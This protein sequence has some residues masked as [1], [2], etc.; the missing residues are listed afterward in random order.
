MAVDDEGVIDLALS[1]ET[2]IVL[3][4]SDHLAWNSF[5]DD[6]LLDDQTH[7]ELLA[8]KINDYLEFW[9][10]GQIA[11]NF[12]DGEGKQGV[13]RVSAIYPMNDRGDWF[14]G[15]MKSKLAE[16]GLRLEFE[17]SETE[18]AAELRNEFSERLRARDG[19]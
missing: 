3:V 10:S 4:I 13:I 18:F 15:E 16:I 17:L 6:D 12:P 14:H 1:T 2:E 19:G 9:E 7:M 11:E 8:N 5:G